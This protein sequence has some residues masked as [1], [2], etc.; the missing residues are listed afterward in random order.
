VTDGKVNVV[1]DQRLRDN[2]YTCLLDA[3]FA[4]DLE[5]TGSIGNLSDSTPLI[6]RLVGAEV[7]IF[8]DGLRSVWPS[9][10]QVHCAAQC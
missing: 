8:I 3:C 4:R 5:L 9:S 10:A 7:S 6:S 1:E 2:Y